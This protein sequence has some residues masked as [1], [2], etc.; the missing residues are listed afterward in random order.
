MRII[1][2]YLTAIAVASICVQATT[3]ERAQE[4]GQKIL[5][6][7]KTAEGKAFAFQPQIPTLFLGYRRNP[8]N[9]NRTL[10]F[11]D[12]LA[13][14]KS[15]FFAT[16]DRST[17]V[18]EEAAPRP[19][20]KPSTTRR[21]PQPKPT[22]RPTKRRPTRA[23]TEQPSSVETVGPKYTDV[24]LE[25]SEAPTLAPIVP[26]HG[27]VFFPVAFVITTEAPT[28]IE[29]VIPKYTDISLEPT[30]APVIIPHGGVYKPI[31]LPG[32]ATEAP[33]AI[34]TVTPK[35]SDISLEPTYAPVIIPHG[36]VYRPIPPIQF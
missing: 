22:R 19:S 5:P 32:S 1:V 28:A 33:T 24:S 21:Q 18:S 23:P 10:F 29:T 2:C 12:I 14:V 8:L 35:Y 30:Y 16:L 31:T 34:E 27:G 13:P 17:E 20:K 3:L 9:S 7:S 36:G 6:Q 11:A 26:R 25:P 4:E 15:S